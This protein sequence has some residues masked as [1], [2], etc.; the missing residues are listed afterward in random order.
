MSRWSE[1]ISNLFSSNQPI[2]FY[3]WVKLLNFFE[4]HKNHLDIDDVKLIVDKCEEYRLYLN[5]HS[6]SYIEPHEVN[7]N[8]YEHLEKLKKQKSRSDIQVHSSDNLVA[9]HQ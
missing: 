8:V 6:C 5:E 9:C 7:P 3:L 2:S 1:N 4:K